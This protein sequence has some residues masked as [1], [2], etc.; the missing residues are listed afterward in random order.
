MVANKYFFK[1]TFSNPTHLKWDPKPHWSLHF[2]GCNS[3]C[4]RNLWAFI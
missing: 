1:R 3:C 2:V 4:S